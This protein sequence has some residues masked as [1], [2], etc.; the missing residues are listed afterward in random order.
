MT[1]QYPEPIARLIDSYMKLPGIGQKTATRLAFYTIDM[2][3][4][5]VNEFAKSLLSVKRDLHF[6][7]ICGNI[8][9]E[10][11]CEIC[12]DPTRDKETIL[13]VEEPKDVMALEKVREYHG[14]YHVLH[15]VLSPMEGTGPE[16]I[17]IA[18]LIQRLHDDQVKEVI[19]ATNATTEGEATAMY[20]SRLIKPAGIKVTRLAHGLSVGSD[21]EYADEVTLLKAVEGRREL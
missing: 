3:E 8:T 7:S 4:E 21:I 16:D 13:V 18:S 9:E 2:K 6:C 20:M 14:L 1:V 12:S 5:V 15:G 19:I 17:N 11:P 10:D